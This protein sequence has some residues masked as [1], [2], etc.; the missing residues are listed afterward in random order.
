MTN[1]CKTFRKCNYSVAGMALVFNDVI[2]IKLW[3]LKILNSFMTDLTLV[4]R[5]FRGFPENGTV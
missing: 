1:D 5:A 4:L 3:T 2:I